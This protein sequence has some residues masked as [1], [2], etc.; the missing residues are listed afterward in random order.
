[1]TERLIRV[2]VTDDSHLI[3][4]LLTKILDSDPM[5]KVVGTA[6]NG[7][8]AVELTKTLAPDIVT[9]D[10]R[11]P[12]MDGFAATKVIMSECPTPIL[13][14]SSSVSRDDLKISFNAIQ[15]GA[16]DII[17]KPRGNL[18]SDYG[19]IGSDI[20]KRVKLVSE[21]HVFKHLSPNLQKT[22]SWSGKRLAEGASEKAVVIGASTGGPKALHQLFMQMPSDFDAPVF[23][24]QHISEGFG[25]GCVDWLDRSSPLKIKTAEDGERVIPG[26]VYFA[27]D[28]GLLELDGRNVIRVRRT[29]PSEERI[30]IDIMIASVAEAY[31]DQ[32]IAVL[33]TGM[34]ND[35]VEGLRAVKGRNGA[36]IAQD[37][38]SSIVF[39][40]P[41]AAIEAG[42]ADNVLS[43]EEIMPAIMKMLVR[44]IGGRE[45]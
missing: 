18:E 12:V 23:V 42:L 4:V 1:M 35:G 9:M 10:I 24:T 25:Q 32:T 13:V 37:K 21:I 11:M 8:E 38:K 7:R 40:M 19:K 44:K 5:I 14:I 15:A 6:R 34:G 17:E 3:R 29:R 27:P 33:M 20:L 36:T 22:I 2:V 31:G 30:P 26:E 41:K 39:G 43:L 28:K 16:L 45:K